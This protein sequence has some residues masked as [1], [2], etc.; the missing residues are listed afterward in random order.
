MDFNYEEWDLLFF[1]FGDL[2][3]S[4]NNPRL[5][6]KRKPGLKSRLL[7]SPRMNIET[8]TTYQFYLR[9]EKGRDFFMGALIEKRKTPERITEESI[10]KWARW[11]FVAMS[12][13]EFEQKIYFRKVIM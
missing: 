13:D 4:R 12:D 3:D 5:D 8:M 7:F 10:L 2:G 6:R 1:Y 11:Y 9:R